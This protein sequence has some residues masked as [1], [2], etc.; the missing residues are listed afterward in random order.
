VRIVAICVVAVYVAWQALVGLARDGRCSELKADPEAAVASARIV[1]ET[2]AEIEACTPGGCGDG[3]AEAAGAGG[4]V[5]VELLTHTG[6]GAA[7]LG[8]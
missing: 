6:D 1:A 2:Q 3:N 5:G 4:R 8:Q 7:T